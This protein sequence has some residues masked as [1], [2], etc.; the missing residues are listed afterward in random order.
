MQK[1]D[2]MKDSQKISTKIFA[3]FILL[4]LSVFAAGQT[5]KTHL[6]KEGLSAWQDTRGW[7]VAGNVTSDPA[8]ES[9]LASK[10]GAGAI[11]N[12]PNGNAPNLHTK[13]NF[14]DCIAH[15]EFMVPKGSNSGVYFMSRYEIQVFDS[16]SVKEPTHSDCG[17]IYQRWDEDRDP[18][19]YEGRP[20]KVN[21]SLPP[22][23]WQSFD[24][25]FKAPRFNNSGKKIQNAEFVKVIHNGILIHED[26]SLTGPTRASTF[27]DEKPAGPLML[28]GDHGPVAYRNI[29]IKPLTEADDIIVNPFFAMDTGTKDNEHQ[30]FADQAQMI[31]ELGYAGFGH[32]HTDL[33]NLQ[34][35][36][37][38]LDAHDLELSTI[39]LGVNL[40]NKEAPFDPRLKDAVKMLDGRGTILWPYIQSSRFDLSSPDG[41]PTAIKVIN[42]MA[43]IIEDTDIKIAFYPHTSFWLETADDAFRLAQKIDRPNVGA[44]F[45]LCHQLRVLGPE[46]LEQT[47][48]KVMPR[49]FV[50]TINGADSAPAGTADWDRLIQPLDA[51][52]FDVYLV[53]KLLRNLNYSGPVGLQHYG[54]KGSAKENLNRSIT[55][56][57]K[58]NVRLTADK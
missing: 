55:A 24:V 17:G 4:C 35:V 10:P 30:T 47:I 54:I 3:L 51:G 5:Q 16:F 29:W 7:Q 6:L 9:K 44:T 52:S 11:I 27:N 19:G 43:D 1:E 37:D 39:Y 14:S 25:I 13:Q 23:S 36:L 15:I 40:D 28:Q 49:L 32:G 42:Q 31:S 38:A 53:L 46:T 48:K 33:D 56:W 57:K 45:N 34:Q 2:N 20:P 22:G 18:K 50:V 58:L 21:A 12:G 41:D 8:N 26:Q